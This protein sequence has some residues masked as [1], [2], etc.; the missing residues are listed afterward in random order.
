MTVTNRYEADYLVSIRPSPDAQDKP[1]LAQSR[2]EEACTSRLDA[3]DV[4]LS[5]IPGVLPTDLESC[6]TAAYAG[7]RS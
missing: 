5:A 3:A 6:P 4:A 7:H 1:G 2:A